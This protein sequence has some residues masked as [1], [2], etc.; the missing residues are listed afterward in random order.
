MKRTFWVLLVLLV[1]SGVSSAQTTEN[2]W[3]E[4]VFYEIFVRSFYD[5]DGDG[6]GDL[7]GVI[8]QLDYL[9]DGDPTT[10]DDLGITGIWLMPIMEAAS[11]HGYDVIDYYTVEQDY[12]TNE[13]F[14]E[15]VA[16]AH[17]RGIMVIVDLVLN[18]TSSEHPWFIESVFEENSKYANYYL[19]SEDDPGYQGPSNQQVWHPNGDRYYYG[20]FWGGMPDLNFTNPMVSQEMYDVTRFW[21]DVMGVDGFRLDAIKHLIEDGEQQEHTSTT[22]AWL[23]NYSQFVQTVKP[24]A[25]LVGEVWS[26]SMIASDYVPDA[27]N[28]VF[29]FD[30]ALVMVDGVRRRSNSAIQ[31]I[32]EQVLELYPPHQY[33]TF[34]T[35]HDQNRVMSEFNDDV[36]S[37]KVAATLLLTSPGVPFIYYGEEIGMMGEKPDERIRTP[38]QWSAAPNTAGF[39]SAHPWQLLDEGYE[40]YNVA[41]QTADPASLLSH[42]R[43]LIQ[44][45][46]AHPAL[47]HGEMIPVTS[48]ERPVYSF[49]RQ[50]EDETLLIVINL[51]HREID[52]Y[53]L[54]LA[55]GNLSGTTRVEVLY[56][57]GDFAVPAINTEGGFDAYKPLA[58][59]PPRSSWVVRLS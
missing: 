10:T 43:S 31:A 48:S 12:G 4:R 58:V 37:A 16:A 41:A 57:E 25:L 45:R 8:E 2:G 38:M 19:W 54:L 46:Q 27:V 26:S 6:I 59:L 47:Q 17:E 14:R 35:N 3:N 50:T 30:L 56:G 51:N 33:A 13:D 32:Q 7:R 40:I 52:D 34:L 20:L 24:G 15:L 22:L 39:T 1:V 55:E 36:G 11:Y 28:L 21:L 29:E 49:I 53:T 18:H 9:N 23:K 44:L 42:Y 5:S